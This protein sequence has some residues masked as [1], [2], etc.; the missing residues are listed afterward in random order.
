MQWN[1][2]QDAGYPIQ[3][4]TND[5]I[6]QFPEYKTYI[7]MYYGKWEQMLGGELKGTVEILNTIIKSK[8]Y[9]VTALKNWSSETF[10]IAKKHF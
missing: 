4:A 10:P 2:N 5:L 7:E 9:K 3:Q 6:N 8:A 1:E